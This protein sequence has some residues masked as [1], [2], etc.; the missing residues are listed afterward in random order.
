MPFDLFRELEQHAEL[1]LKLINRK[2]PPLCLPLLGYI[3]SKNVSCPKRSA[4]SKATRQ[5]CHCGQRLG[6]KYGLCYASVVGLYQIC[7][8]SAKFIRCQRSQASATNKIKSALGYLEFDKVTGISYMI[9]VGYT[10][11]LPL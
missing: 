2:M 3:S 8:S 5:G 11:A 10:S 4:G 1:L 9:C 7:F 6:W